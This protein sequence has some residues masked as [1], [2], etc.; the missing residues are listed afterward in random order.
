M[1]VQAFVNS[2]G[3]YLAI[4]SL[5]GRFGKL[6][7]QNQLTVNQPPHDFEGSSPS[8]PT[9]LRSRGEQGC[10]AEARRAK[11]GLWA[12]GYGSAS[13]PRFALAGYAWRSHAET[14]RPKRCPA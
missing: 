6:I 13:H 2:R 1:F 12:R 3:S 9:S 10:R 14:V 5:C 4:T 7:S 8:S 11:A